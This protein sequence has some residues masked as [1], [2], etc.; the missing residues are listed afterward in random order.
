M[1]GAKTSFETYDSWASRNEIEMMTVEKEK[2]REY[3]LNHFQTVAS[4][5]SVKKLKKILGE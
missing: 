5:N 3:L 4:E 1:A 2:A